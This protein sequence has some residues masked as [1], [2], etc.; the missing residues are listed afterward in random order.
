MQGSF[1]K[2]MSPLLDLKYND[3][4]TVDFK[5]PPPKHV[6]LDS[7]F[8]KNIGNI[9]HYFDKEKIVFLYLDSKTKAVTYDITNGIHRKIKGSESPNA[10]DNGMERILHIRLGKES[11]FQEDIP[12]VYLHLIFEISSVTRFF[13][14]ARK[15]QLALLVIVFLSCLPLSLKSSHIPNNVTNYKNLGKK[16]PTIDFKY[17]NNQLTLKILDIS[18][19]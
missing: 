10:M 3:S 12:P 8:G 14:S 4:I 2:V 18:R 16:E 17:V 11:L 13:L 15:R 5:L 9:V 7:S 6:D 1:F 19:I